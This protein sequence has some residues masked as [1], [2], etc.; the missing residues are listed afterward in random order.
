MDQITPVQH[1]SNVT[2]LNNAL[3]NSNS[4]KST[5]ELKVYIV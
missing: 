2:M 3:M 4:T 1:L 5:V